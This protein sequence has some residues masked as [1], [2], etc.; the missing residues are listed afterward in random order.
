MNSVFCIVLCVLTL[1]YSGLTVLTVLSDIS[2]SNKRSNSVCRWWQVICWLQMLHGLVSQ[3]LKS[4]SW[5]YATMLL[6]YVTGMWSAL[7]VNRAV[8]PLLSFC[9]HGKVEA[10]HISALSEG[11]RWSYSRCIISIAQVYWF[12]HKNKWR[13]FMFFTLPF[14][15][16]VQHSSAKATGLHFPKWQ[17]S[18]CETNSKLFAITFSR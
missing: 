1:L 5:R 8:H 10:W 2:Q 6:C 13:S 12:T 9:Y 4:Q 17:Q 14:R 16:H 11:H 15:L 7:L 3:L 18:A